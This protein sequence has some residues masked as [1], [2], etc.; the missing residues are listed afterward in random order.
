MDCVNGSQ[1]NETKK[2]DVYFG[3][4]G[5]GGSSITPWKGFGY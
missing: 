5:G 1:E 2:S 4:W 3:E